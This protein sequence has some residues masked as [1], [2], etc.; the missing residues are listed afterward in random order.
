M[1]HPSRSRSVPLL[2]L[3]ICALPVFAEPPGDWVWQN[4]LPQGNSLEAV[5]GRSATEVYAIGGEQTLLRWDGE[6]WSAAARP[7]SLPIFDLWGLDSGVLFAAGWGGTVLR[8]DGMAWTEIPTDF[9][10]NLVA[11]LAFSE[12][13]IFVAERFP[14]ARIRHY[15][16]VGWTE[17]GVAPDGIH[18]L[19]GSG[20]A[21]IYAA[22]FYGMMIHYDGVE[23]TPVSGFPSLDITS[24]WSN[25]DDDVFALQQGA[26]L[27]HFDGLDWTQVGSDGTSGFQS[28]MW[29]TSASDVWFVDQNGGL[30]HYD[31]FAITE[32]DLPNDGLLGVWG[33]DLGNVHAVGAHGSL[34][35]FNGN[36]WTTHSSATTYEGLNA[37]WGLG[38][39]DLYA[40]GSLEIVI[41]YDG[42]GW[43]QIHPTQFSVWFNDI[44]A[45]AADDVYVVGK[46]GVK[47][48]DG[49]DWIPMDDGLRHLLLPLNGVW[50]FGP[51]DIVAVADWGAIVRY[52]GEE[53][54]IVRDADPGQGD[55]LAVWGAAPDDIWAVGPQ[56]EFFHWDGL[57]W[58]L[59]PM[60]SQGEQKA[61]VGWASDDIYVLGTGA[62]LFHFDGVDWTLHTDL[63]GYGVTSIHGTSSSDLYAVTAY[64][65]VL[66][67][68]G[69]IWTPVDTAARTGLNAIWAAASGEVFVVGEGG[70]VLA[71]STPTTATPEFAI[72]ERLHLRGE[73]N[74]F[75]PSISLRFEMPRAGHATLVIHDIS[76][77]QIATL[78]DREIPAGWQTVRWDG[79]DGGGRQQASG[80]YFASVRTEFGREVQKLTLV[81]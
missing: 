81:K 55:L 35:S 34:L 61:I 7:I 46:A 40:V 20:P 31:G 15:D 67:H 75:N 8:Y 37:V 43:T 56:N 19:G 70:S 26:L 36:A 68:D 13:D 52:D 73:P 60:S 18:D 16:G 78:L 10:D 62:E 80:V 63:M 72:G 29:G 64:G 9:D 41:H 65:V 58:H 27:H 28:D 21:D 30:S 24:V 51:D 6:A 76:G 74:P 12:T 5:W 33:D 4:P 53:W 45:A 66:H 3:C 23:W 71:G 44:W 69:V 32:Y 49:V 14:G 47:H 22:G 48:Y 11:I 59:V 54:T 42:A 17:I 79:R 1:N 38:P 50:G 39:D 57:D 77:R 25:A 2:I